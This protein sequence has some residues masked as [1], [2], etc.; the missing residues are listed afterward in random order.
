VGTP[1]DEN[2]G[3]LEAQGKLFKAQ[4]S[5]FV[6]VTARF[7][8]DKMHFV[9]EA[10][11]RVFSCARRSIEI[12]PRVA[13]LERKIRLPDGALFQ[14]T[15]TEFV[16]DLDQRKAWKGIAS[17][18]RFG[19][20]LIVLAVAC[21]GGFF[22]VYRFGLPLLVK[23]A[24]AMTPVEVPELMDAGT[25]RSMDTV[26]TGPSKLPEKRQD[27][28]RA[29]FDELI[30]AYKDSGKATEGKSFNFMFRDSP[31]IGPNAFALP[32]GTIIM[33]DQLVNDF[34]DE[35]LLAGILSHE[36]GHVN[37]QHSLQQLYRALGMAALVTL[38]AGD[39]GP[40]LEDVI[41][42]GNALLSLSFSRA[43]ESEADAFSVDLMRRVG[44]DPEGVAR[45]FIAIQEKYDVKMESSWMSTHPGA[46]ERIEAIRK[47]AAESAK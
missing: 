10:G 18:E 35:E 4:S 36:I 23:A 13:S 21:L 31:R 9:D 44:R 28:L 6:E 46:K 33:T 37:H 41:W 20:H 5:A 45:F 39:S 25:L 43:H 15:N 24:I 40:I 3:A 11:E 47:L 42:E 7:D 29:V 1:D 38:I 17:L 12:E 32:G 2:T 27:E 22:A 14:T 30:T 16:D 26:L 8:G 19:P 34:D